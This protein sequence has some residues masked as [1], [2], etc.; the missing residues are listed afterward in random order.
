MAGRWGSQHAI[1]VAAALLVTSLA[2]AP[3]AAASLRGVDP[4]RLPTYSAAHA[5][6]T[7]ECFDGSKRVASSAVNDN[8]CDCTDGSDEPGMRIAVDPVTLHSACCAMNGDLL[9]HITTVCVLLW[10]VIAV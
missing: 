4:A 9:R 10:I 5:S 8:Y 7:L 6:G 1:A 2:G 3:H